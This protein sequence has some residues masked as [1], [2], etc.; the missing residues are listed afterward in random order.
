MLFTLPA[1]GALP[2]HNDI[3]D[4]LNLA[5]VGA[6][7]QLGTLLQEKKV[8]LLRAQYD[9]SVSGGAVGIIDLLDVDGK[10]AQIPGGAIIVGCLMDVITAPNTMGM[11][12]SQISFNR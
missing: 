9:Y 1:L 7:V 3:R 5:P 12:T 2:G 4:E 6:R 11:N 10:K 8:Q